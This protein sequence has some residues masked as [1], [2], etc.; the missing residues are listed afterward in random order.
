MRANSPT[1]GALGSI[2]EG[3]RA[4][5]ESVLGSLEQSQSKEQLQYNLKRLHNITND[6]VHGVGAGPDRYDLS[7]GAG[8]QQQSGTSWPQRVVEQQSAAPAGGGAGNIGGMTIDQARAVA[9]D[10][11]TLARMSPEERAALAARL[12]AGR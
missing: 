9:M 4:A 5:L 10:D 7:G 3:E 11:A 1:G 2:T 12:R 8:Q 6:I